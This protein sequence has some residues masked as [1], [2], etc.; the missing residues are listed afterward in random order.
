MRNFVYDATC[1]AE[2]LSVQV[3]ELEE[4]P[5][6]F[7]LLEEVVWNLVVLVF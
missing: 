4:L 1:G 6:F 7:Q 2:M 3:V 5:Y